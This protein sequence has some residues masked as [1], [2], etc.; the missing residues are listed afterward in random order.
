MRK[1]LGLMAFERSEFAKKVI[2]IKLPFTDIKCLI[3][4]YY[5]NLF[6]IFSFQ[7][8][9]KRHSYTKVQKHFLKTK[10]RKAFRICHIL[11]YFFFIFK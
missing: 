10:S 11:L 2:L 5:S 6:C 8:I 3:D 4:F 9:S 1:A 7:K